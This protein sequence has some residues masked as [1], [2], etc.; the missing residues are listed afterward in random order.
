LASPLAPVKYGFTPVASPATAMAPASTAAGFVAARVRAQSAPPL[1]GFSP[2]PAHIFFA[3][4][5]AS[6]PFRLVPGPV[7]G[8]HVRR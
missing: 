4:P 5:L 7:A 3:T 8:M 2:S 6:S 1:A